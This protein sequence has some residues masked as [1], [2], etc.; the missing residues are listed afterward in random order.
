MQA[1]RVT[2][3]T[4][5]QESNVLLS[6]DEAAAALSLGRSAVYDLIMRKELA[7]IKVGRTRRVPVVALHQYVDR[8]LEDGE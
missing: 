2:L 6:V 7:S 1:R 4:I 5:G 3:P 8:R